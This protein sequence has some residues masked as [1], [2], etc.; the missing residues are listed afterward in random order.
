MHGT[1]RVQKEAKV[2]PKCGKVFYVGGERIAGAGGRRNRVFCSAECAHKQR[3]PKARVLTKSERAWLAGLFDGEGSIVLPKGPHTNSLRLSVT[4]TCYPL[5]E[6]ILSVTGTGA[7]VNHHTATEKHAQCWYWQ[8]Y[9]DNA[10][11]LLRQMLPWL[12]VK[13]EKA[14]AVL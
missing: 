14:E 5:L 3:Q 7:I 1:R 12:I 10:R 11:S 9:A 2:C 4:N 6:Q 8:C 13:R